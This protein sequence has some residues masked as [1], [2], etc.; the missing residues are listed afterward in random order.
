MEVRPAPS[1][2]EAQ[3]SPRHVHRQQEAR[4][5]GFPRPPSFPSSLSFEL[6]AKLPSRPAPL[7]SCRRSRPLSSAEGSLSSPRPTS[8]TEKRRTSALRKRDSYF[9]SESSPSGVT[10]STIRGKQV[11]RPVGTEL[12]G[13][14]AILPPRFLALGGQKPTF[15]GSCMGVFYLV[16]KPFARLAL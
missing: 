1:A 2:V 9:S 14:A 15:A 5:A 10:G 13:T 8:T 16:D 3:P 7:R 4:R 12:T 6:H 11:N